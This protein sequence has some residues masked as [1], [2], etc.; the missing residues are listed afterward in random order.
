VAPGDRLFIINFHYYFF[1]NYLLHDLVHGVQ[2]IKDVAVVGMPFAESEIR[3]AV[4]EVLA[5]LGLISTAPRQVSD[6]IE[7][8]MH[9]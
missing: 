3:E 2:N 4:N 7:R 8:A 6:Y 9:R 5:N 1:L